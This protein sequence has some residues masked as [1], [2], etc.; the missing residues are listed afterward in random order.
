[1]KASA[2]IAIAASDDM[3]DPKAKDLL[4]AAFTAAGLPHEVKVYEGTKHGW[5]PTDSGVY[6]HDE[7]EKAWA[8]LL[9]VFG[10]ALA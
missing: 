8:R 1:M 5:C 4:E 9:D 6:D 7:A 2:L 10:K 3:S